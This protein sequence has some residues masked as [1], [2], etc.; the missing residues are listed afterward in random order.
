M[1]VLLPTEFYEFTEKMY[2]SYFPIAFQRKY[3]T[4]NSKWRNAGALKG[5]KK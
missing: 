5:P 2:L 4:H 3:E 1:I